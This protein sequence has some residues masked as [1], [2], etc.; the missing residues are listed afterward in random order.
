[1]EKLHEMFAA[2]EDVPDSF[3]AF[4]DFAVGRRYA[5]DVWDLDLFAAA[6]PFSHPVLILH[7]DKDEEVPYSYSERAAALYTDAQLICKYGAGHNFINGYFDGV[8]D[9]ILRF[10][11]GFYGR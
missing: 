8:M 4:S 3:E 6:G 11:R 9:D 10:L 7:G 5:E 2:L 1:M